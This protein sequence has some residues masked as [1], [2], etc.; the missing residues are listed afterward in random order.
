MMLASALKNESS[1]VVEILCWGAR[2]WSKW[3][4]ELHLKS[5]MSK[6]SWKLHSVLK[7]EMS[8][9][10][11]SLKFW[12]TGITSD[13]SF[14]FHIYSLPYPTICYYGNT[15]WKYYGHDCVD[16]NKLWKILKEMG[17]PDHLICLFRSNGTPLHYSCLENPMDRGAW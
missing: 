8:Q 17:I 14:T 11:L 3:I 9:F 15:K 2:N 12:N 5:S 13:L 1:E 16:H 7:L 10:H 6:S 4:R